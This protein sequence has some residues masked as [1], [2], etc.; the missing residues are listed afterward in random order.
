MS[1]ASIS[2]RRARTRRQTGNSVSA[3]DLIDEPPL[4]RRKPFLLRRKTQRRVLPWVVIILLFAL[5]EAV[6]RLFAIEPFLLPA[7]SAMFAAGWQ[8]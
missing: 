4:K 7:P 8:W 5:W 1:F 2:V 3:S 6:V